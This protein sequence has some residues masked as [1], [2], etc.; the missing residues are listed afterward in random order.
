LYF[1]GVVVKE[2]NMKNNLGRWITTIAVVLTNLIIWV[3]PSDL[4][5]NVAQHRDILLGR[6]TVERVTTILLLA[7]ASALI[8]N[9]IWSRKKKNAK[10]KKEDNFK[11]IALSI[12]I[13]VSLLVV[14]VSMRVIQRRQYFKNESFY[15]RVPN[16]VQHGINKDVP[17]T[18]F[19]YP[20]TSV[21]YPDVEYTL[22]ID[23]K[24]FR[25]KTELDKYDI[26]VL[27]DSFTEGSHV[28][29]GQAWPFLLAAK[30]NLT[31]YNLGMS[32]GSPVTYLET[33]KRFGLNRAPKIVICML[34][35]GNDFRSSNFDEN[36]KAEQGWNLKT[37]FDTSPLRYSIKNALIRCLGPINSNRFKNTGSKANQAQ[38]Y[39]PSHPLYAVSWL[40][41]AIPDS[42]DAKYY[43]F[44]IKRLLAHFISEDDFLDS[45]GC[46][47]TF[48]RLR[49]IKKVCDENNIRFVI[50]YAPD[51]PHVLLP[52]VEDTLCPDKLRAFMALKEKNLPAADKLVE[53]LMGR[54]NVQESAAEAFCRREQIEF[55]SMTQPLR[56]RISKGLQAYYTYDQHWTPIGHE[57][58][59]DALSH[60]IK[61]S[62][63]EELK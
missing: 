6:Y 59:A 57:I 53:A 4:A 39:P 23:N 15:H 2:N 41:L 63:N 24:G 45:Q 11:F 47:L 32:A 61:D 7:I 28:S 10:E 19:S 52:I 21:G 48:Q 22:T 29:D 18:A 30:S 17:P 51:K 42:P 50:A 43:A 1:I 46:K 44:K 54:L 3:I 60:N 5:Y 8:L 16:T 37:Y 38:L 13:I 56:Q 55:V 27:G 9:G 36:K 35:E 58:A 31:V 34:Y 33:L 62:T 20:Q 12:S 49:E 26:V 40:P 25:N 14:D